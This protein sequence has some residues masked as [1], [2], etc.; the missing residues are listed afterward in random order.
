MWELAECIGR[1]LLKV[2][3]LESPSLGDGSVL[4]RRQLGSLIGFSLGRV[5]DVVPD[6][7]AIPLATIDAHD[8]FA[9][10]I[11]RKRLVVFEVSGFLL[12]A[13]SF[14]SGGFAGL[15]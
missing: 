11:L 5:L 2:S 14:G 15:L 12:E 7:F 10:V 3:I 4:I 1:Y 8:C 6:P 9:G 13:W